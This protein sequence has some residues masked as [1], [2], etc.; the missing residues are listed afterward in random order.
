LCPFGFTVAAGLRWF[1]FSLLLD[2]VVLPA[3]IAVAALAERARAPVPTTLGRASAAVMTAQARGGARPP[4]FCLG[5]GFTNGGLSCYDSA[6]FF[7]AFLPVRVLRVDDVRL[8]R[9][10]G[11]K[12]RFLVQDCAV[13]RVETRW[14]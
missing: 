1:T 8:F 14:T 2:F 12:L 4:L 6:A 13:A 9:G 5:G 10:Y 7:E 3:E 11:W